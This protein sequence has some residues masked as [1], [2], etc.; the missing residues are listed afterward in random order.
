M[1]FKDTDFTLSMCSGS[2]VRKNPPVKELSYSTYMAVSKK[3]FFFLTNHF[4]LSNY[5]TYGLGIKEQKQKLMAVGRK[6][7]KSN[8]KNNN[9]KVPD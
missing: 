9:L 7:K 2:T 8:Y 4:N 3:N 5:V 6:K 1:G